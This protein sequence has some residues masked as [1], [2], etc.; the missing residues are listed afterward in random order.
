M[1][2]RRGCGAWVTGVGV[3]RGSPVWVWSVGRWISWI[4]SQTLRLRLEDVHWFGCAAWVVESR[5]LC[6]RRSVSD[7]KTFTGLGVE[8]GSPDL[9]DRVPNALSRTLRRS[10]VRYGPRR[11]R[12]YHKKLGSICGYWFW[13]SRHLICGFWSSCR[14]GE[15]LVFVDLCLICGFWFMECCLCLICGFWSSRR[16]WSIWDM[17]LLCILGSRL[18]MVA[19]VGW[20]RVLGSHGG[21]WRGTARSFG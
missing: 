10:L 1:G 9:A 18:M 21:C 5:G 8:R 11:H 19:G 14:R 4:V 12:F 16:G 20:L 13:S 2:H 15:L 17:G 7:S 3:E 6:P